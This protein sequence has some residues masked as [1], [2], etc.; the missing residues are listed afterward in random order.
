M[1]W[2]VVLFQIV[3]A[4]SIL[5]VWLVQK[6]K[7]TPWRGGNAKTLLE[8]FQVYGL[9]KWCYYF[10]GSLK[11]ILSLL[12]L[13]A[14][15]FP[16]LKLAVALGLMA[17]LFGSVIMHLKINDTIKKLLPATVFLLMCLYIA[18]PFPQ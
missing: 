14:I 16:L 8:E 4:V 17:L 15:W 10:I 7:A 3:V 9:P 13:I 18:F 1:S 5:R 2:L 11:V 12:L 6:N